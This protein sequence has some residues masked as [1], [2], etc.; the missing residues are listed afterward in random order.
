M[1]GTLGLRVIEYRQLFQ[2]VVMFLLVQFFGLLLATMLFSGVSYSTLKGSTIASSGSGVIYYILYI[3]AFAVILS[4]V[5]KIYKGD[6]LFVVLEGLV[7]FISSYMVFLILFGSL[8]G[9]AAL[10][11]FGNGP[12]L[13]FAFAALSA[14]ALVAAKNLRPGLR[15]FTALLSSAG[16]GVILG[17]SFSF[18]AAMLF[19]FLLAIYDFIAVFITKHMLTLADAVTKKNLSFMIDVNEIEAIPY[20]ALS[21]ADRLEYRNA[22]PPNSASSPLAE[23]LKSE[24]L[25]PVAAR[26]A[27]GTG[28]L[29]TPLML[30]VSAYSVHHNFVLSFVIVAGASFGLAL[31]MLILRKYK[32]A[33]PAIP[34]I[35]FGILVALAI[36]YLVL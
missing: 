13:P 7:I 32:R 19:M 5:F 28:D 31:T 33:L 34:P 29:G 11:V 24:G 35:L 20:S 36:Y 1:S 21:K 15:N 25:V 22:N 12:L 23:R 14:L 9:S 30:A 18:A 6:K 10:L 16:V 17:I 8:S 2:I 4:M 26:V 3:V 27:L